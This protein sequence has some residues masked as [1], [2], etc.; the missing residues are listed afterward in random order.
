MPV[1]AENP[2]RRRGE[3]A[4]LA[5]LAAPRRG[6][7]MLQR[8]ASAGTFFRAPKTIATT[9]TQPQT[10]STFIAAVAYSDTSTASSNNITEATASLIA[11]SVTPSSS[12]VLRLEPDPTRI[13]ETML[14][15]LRLRLLQLRKLACLTKFTTAS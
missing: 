10:T 14:Q 13:L 2:P 1:P 9:C 3:E 5:R 12:L 7:V 8:L 6:S 15:V 11:L 4:K